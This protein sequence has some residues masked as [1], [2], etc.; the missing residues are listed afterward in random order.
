MLVLGLLSL[1]LFIGIRLAPSDVSAHDQVEYA[2]VTVAP[3]DT[4]W[5]IASQYRPVGVD[6][7]A[8]VDHIQSLNGLRSPLI[9]P[10]QV[11]K[12]PTS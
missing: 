4:L 10:G 6:I 7:R 9:Q 12:V 3:G 11:L 1:L 8:F 2:S 5:D